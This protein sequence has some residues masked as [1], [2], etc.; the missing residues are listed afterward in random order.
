MNKLDF[1]AINAALDPETMVPRWLPEGHKRGKEWVAPNPTRADTTPGSF[2]INLNTGRW[3]DFATGD[4]GKDLVSLYAY[5]FHG[6][7]Q[8]EAARALAGDHGITPDPVA[9]QQAVEKIKNI[10]ESRPRMILPVPADAPQEPDEQWCAG[11]RHPEFGMPSRVWPYRDRE[12]RLLLYV[13][14][15][16]VEPRKQVMPWSWC[17]D[18]VKN[19]TRWTI[20]GFTGKDKRPLYGLDRLQAMPDADVLMVEGEKA[21]DAGQELMGQ[22]CAVVTWMGGVESADKVSVR[23][24]DGRRVILFPDFDAQREPLTK[25][26]KQACVDPAS[27][28][29]LPFHEQPGIRA[30]MALAQQLKGVAREVLL[31]GYDI[32]PANAGWDLADGQ[33]EGWTGAQV[34]QYIAQRAGDPQHIASGKASKPAGAP[35]PANDNAQKLPL[36]AAVNPFGYVHLSEKGQP[37]NT[38]E[39]LEYLLDEYGITARYNETRKQVEVHLPGRTYSVDNR[40]NCSLAELNSICARN[41]MPQSMLSDYVKLIADRNAYNPVRD[42]ITSKP[43]DGISRLQALYDTITVKGDTA[44]RDMLIYRWM[45]SCVAAVFVERGFESHGVLVFTGEQGQGK[46]KWVKRLVPADLD[47]V[48][49]GAVLDP[50]NKDTI[51]NAVSHWLVELGELDATFRKADIARLKSFITNSVDKLRRPYDRIESEYQRRTVFF[52]SVNE[53][54]YLVDDTGNRRWWTIAAI[55]V[56]YEHDLDMQ[57]VW[58]ELLTHYERGERWYLT[59]EEQQMLQEVNQEHEAVDPVEEQIAT[60]FDWNG[61]GLFRR[62]MTA[63]EV[64]LAIG[65]DKPTKQQA[66]HASKVLK[67]LTGGEPTRKNSGRYFS[68]P[69]MTGTKAARDDVKQQQDDDTRAF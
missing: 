54:K 24:L 49:V 38:V 66:T 39:N 69:R 9:R 45:L 23:A 41:R 61:G 30:M 22:A 31:V 7:D 10:E 13:A 28:P 50:N 5:L 15:Y 26:E 42:W 20:R 44:M 34:L 27:K 19:R 65:Y 12:G 68:M 17:F 40:A 64:L 58:A 46:T 53:S 4:S 51:T 36:D 1:D 2:S 43:W 29:L 63:T 6:D 33:A 47:V 48:L 59:R 14:R 57:Q 8:G 55:A 25:E 16:D 3:K 32:D 60:S 21:A 37:M 67:K 35:T 18:P 62:E 52:A 56:N 11:F